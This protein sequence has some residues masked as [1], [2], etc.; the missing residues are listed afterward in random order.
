M[1]LEHISSSKPKIGGAIY[2]APID[3]TVPTDG[4]SE[5]TKGKNKFVCLGYISD[6]GLKHEIESE[7]EE[8]KAFGGDTVLKTQTSY[9]EKF[10]YTLWESLNV[11]VLKHVYGEGAVSGD[12]ESGI[13]IARSGAELPRIRAVIELI[14][15]DGYIKRIVAPNAQVT[16]VGGVEYKDGEIVG[17]EVTLTTFRD[18]KGKFVYEYVAKPAGLGAERA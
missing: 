2:V 5:L 11:D 6:D 12:L 17:F 4:T 16:E 14:L 13:T 18:E 1:G 10:T 15:K 8:K 9:S 7:T 3:A